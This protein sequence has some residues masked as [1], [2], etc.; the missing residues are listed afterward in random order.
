MDSLVHA[1]HATGTGSGVCHVTE[2]G[3]GF[4]RAWTGACAM[5]AAAGF[6]EDVETE[7]MNWSLA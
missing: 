4:A 3:V 1:G 2:T 7:V 5:T 6:E